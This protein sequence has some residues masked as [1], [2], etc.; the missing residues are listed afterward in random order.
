[1]CRFLISN[2]GAGNQLVAPW[3][4]GY[5]FWLARAAFF[6]FGLVF[7][8]GPSVFCEGGDKRMGG[9]NSKFRFEIFFF[10]LFCFFDFF[11]F[12]FFFF[13]FFFFLVF[14]FVRVD[15]LARRSLPPGKSAGLLRRKGG[16]ALPR[17]SR[18]YAFSV[19]FFG[20]CLLGM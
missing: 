7:A 16:L 3:N 9:C 5:T 10:F 12:L 2:N 6:S 11:F 14:F 13:F 20:L 8:R 4:A 17:A 15:I 1:V 19:R 18:P